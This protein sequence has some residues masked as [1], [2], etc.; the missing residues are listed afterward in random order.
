MKPL[1]A[2]DVLVNVFGPRASD[3]HTHVGYIK[4]AG[5]ARCADMFQRRQLSGLTWGLGI[6]NA[7]K[8]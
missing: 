3:V 4:R 8:L 1:S 6:E 2:H 5:L 7:A